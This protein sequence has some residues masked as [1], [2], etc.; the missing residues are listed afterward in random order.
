MIFPSHITLIIVLVTLLVILAD[1]QMLHPQVLCFPFSFWLSSLP[2]F[3]PCSVLIMVPNRCHCCLER[4]D[5][6]EYY[7]LV[8]S[9]ERKKESRGATVVVSPLV[10]PSSPWTKGDWQQ[11]NVQIVHW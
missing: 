5:P 6:T 11:P 2:H 3:C 8:A 9:A 4:D 10:P 1:L 7:L